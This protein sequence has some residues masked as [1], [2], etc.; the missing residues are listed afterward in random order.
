MIHPILFTKERT[1]IVV[2]L[3]L[4]TLKSA[5]AV[6]L[7]TDRQTDSQGIRRKEGKGLGFSGWNE[8]NRTERQIED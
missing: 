7:Q 8:Q 1:R 5:W 2:D 4:S 3:F 6:L